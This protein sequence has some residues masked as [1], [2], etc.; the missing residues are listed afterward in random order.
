VYN[1]SGREQVASMTDTSAV[2]PTCPACGAHAAGKFCEQCGTP[3]AVAACPSCGT[4]VSANARFC[5]E[6]GTVVRGAP[7]PTTGVGRTVG[8]QPRAI[9]APAAQTSSVVRYAPWILATVLLCAVVGFFAG[10]GT[11]E[12]TADAGGAGGAGG[13]PFAAGAA[14]FANG[15]GGGKPPDLSTMSPRE[16]ASRLYDRIMRYA[17]EGKTDSA[18][19]FAPMAMAS[20]ELLGAELDLDARYDYGRVASE[21]GNFD[22]ALA[23]ADTILKKSPGHLLGLALVARTATKKGDAKAAA[24]AWKLFLAAKESELKKNLPEYQE[25]AADIENATKLARGGK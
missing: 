25:H 2:L 7:P 11:G 21:T 1:A 4:S 6:C 18:S 9:E 20:F 23:Q 3:V 13:A 17:E 24:A 22:V 14:P 10:K 16:R 12:T 8:A 19:F 5:P 15:G